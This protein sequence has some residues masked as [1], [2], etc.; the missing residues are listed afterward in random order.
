MCG[1]ISKLYVAIFE[2]CIVSTSWLKILP[3]L[4]PTVVGGVAIHACLPLSCA[5]Y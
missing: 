4:A 3:K 5:V 1:G 2:V